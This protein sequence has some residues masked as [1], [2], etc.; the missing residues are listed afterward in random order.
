[1]PA[2]S[3]TDQYGAVSVTIHWLS[4]V[5][6]M[7][8]IASGLRADGLEDPASKADLL[9]AHVPLGGT[10][11]LL[12]VA[13]IGWWFFA[14]KKPGSLPMP[15]WQRHFSRAVH[16]L[17]YVMILGITASGIGMMVLSGA[18]P[19]LFGGSAMNLPNFNDYPPRIPHGIGARVMIAILVLHAGAALY[20][21]FIR[22][23]R[24]LRRMWFGAR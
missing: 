21:Q 9:R 5:L 14:E 16:V 7:V 13:R 6:I 10:V 17:F 23:D 18:G 20:H 19:F 8:L 11:L 4:A 15:I 24:L 2:K 3:T 12:T 1:M 22:G